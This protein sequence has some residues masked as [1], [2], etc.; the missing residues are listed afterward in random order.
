MSLGT[1]TCFCLSVS[2]GQKD[3]YMFLSVPQ[4]NSQDKGQKH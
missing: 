1:I 2:Q 3:I 4:N